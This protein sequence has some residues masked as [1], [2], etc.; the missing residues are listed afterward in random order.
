MN[1][2]FNAFGVFPTPVGVFLFMYPKPKALCRLPHARGGVSGERRSSPWK[3]LSSPRPWGCFWFDQDKTPY[4]M[5]FPTPVGVFLVTLFAKDGARGL[6]HA[7]GGVSFTHYESVRGVW[8]SPRPWGCFLPRRPQP[9]A[10]SV[11]P[12]PVGVFPS[13]RCAAGLFFG[14]PHARG[15]VSQCPPGVREKFR[16]SPRP[17]GCFR[18]RA[19]G[20]LQGQVFPTPVGVFLCGAATAI[21]AVSLPHARGGVSA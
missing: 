1:S 5:V 16:S 4:E 13:E 14:L 3:G 17:W 7:R 19:G 6:P 21:M 2:T 8:S 18:P 12:T 10:L 20:G 15:G 11:F 9:G